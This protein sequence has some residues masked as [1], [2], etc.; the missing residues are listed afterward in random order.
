MFRGPLLS[1]DWRHKGPY[2]VTVSPLSERRPV[3][4][5]TRNCPGTAEPGPVRGAVAVAIGLVPVRAAQTVAAYEARLVALLALA[6]LSGARWPH[7]T[8]ARASSAADRAGE[9]KKG[10]GCDKPRTFL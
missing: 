9:H 1:C 2:T 6:G 4:P 8:A 3:N 7:P 10:S 5:R